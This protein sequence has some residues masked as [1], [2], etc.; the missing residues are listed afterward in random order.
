M[1]Y[2]ANFIGDYLIEQ[3]M[4]TPEQL[5]EALQEQNKT[6]GRI[7]EI[8]VKKGFVSEDNF[9]M[10]LGKQLGIPFVDI[11]SYSINPSVVKLLPPEL[12][13]KHQAIPI[14]RVMDAIT[15]AMVDPL[16]IASVDEIKKACR[17][18]VRPVFATPSGIKEAI[19]KYYGI[20]EDA[21]G[22]AVTVSPG[23]SVETPPGGGEPVPD[24]VN[25]LVKEAA[26][27]PVVTLV[28]SLIT[29]AVEAG[30]SDIHLEPEEKTL[31]VRFRIDGILQ[32]NNQVSKDLEPAVLSRIKIMAEMD[33]A[34]KRLPQDGRIKLKIMERDI[35]LRVST[36][37]TIYGEN[38]VIRI[39]DKSQALFRLEDLGF[40][41][42]VLATF[43]D[44]LYRPYGIILVT[45]PTGSGKTTTLY[46]A[47][48]LINDVTKNILTM[49]D[50]IE[51]VIPR[52]RQ[53]QVNSKAGLTFAT[54]LRATLRHDPD[55]IMI[56]EIRDRE[57][58]E[59]AIQAAL[60][61]HLV[62][63]TLH[64]N[65]AASAVTRLIDMGVEP[66]LVASSLLGIMAQRLARRLCVKCRKPYQPIDEELLTLGFKSSRVPEAAFYKEA[67][68]PAC[69]QTGYKGRIGVY[70]LLIPD[71]SFKEL[72][73]KKSP[74]H[75]I[76]EYAASKGMIT[77]RDDGLDKFRQG[78]ISASEIVRITMDV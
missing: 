2:S 18:T 22:V 39:L 38:I 30:A 47:L 50:P 9:V 75:Q 66:F 54:G 17:L 53:T 57:T 52:V 46:G 76:R 40:N 23:G 21:A 3:H 71:E 49:E 20:K 60:T 61:G 26:Q 12:A 74:P 64:T 44:I 42:L 13:Q 8:L 25:A 28:N 19:R 33:I 45:G 15:L 67:G 14:N 59:I 55:I 56:G 4:I 62:F 63:S 68:C 72:V 65:D 69:R 36:L 7:G 51:Y 5:Q 58:A 41:P 77:L 78:V 1:A 16:G 34:E 10:A 73:L 35:D 43:K 48:N 6:K 31:Y 70:E 32:D 27:A 11:R 24:D 37:P 29:Q